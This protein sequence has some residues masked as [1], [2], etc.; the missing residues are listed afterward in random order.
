MIVASALK[1]TDGSVHIGYRH[2]DIFR[3]SGPAEKK[4][5]PENYFLNCIQGFITDT[6]KFLDRIE[7]RKHAIECG[8]IDHTNWGERLYS[9][10][11]W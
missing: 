3:D 1:A 6:G 7:A 9:E 10:D 11:L 4:F 2:A 8:Q 5:G